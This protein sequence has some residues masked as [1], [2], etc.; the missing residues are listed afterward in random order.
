MNKKLYSRLDDHL[1]LAKK[2][3]RLITTHFLDENQLELAKIYLK[4]NFYQVSTTPINAKRKI[5]GFNGDPNDLIVCLV[6]KYQNN[7]I[8]LKYRDVYG[9]LMGLNL[10]PEVIGDINV[11]DDKVAI[12]IL[13]KV[14]DDILYNLIQINK[15]YLKFEISEEHYYKE[16]AFLDY[17]DIIS[18]LRLDCVVKSFAKVSRSHANDLIKQ[19]YVKINHLVVDKATTIVKENDI[20]SIRRSGRYIFDGV[21]KQ[22][23]KD[24]LLIQYRKYD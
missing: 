9:A 18:S 20:I 11:F 2:T 8:N 24:K 17:Q 6:A 14:K 16:N 5:I 13:D 10:S 23:K 21:I 22:T 4:N 15:I 19:Q 12:Y 1:F 7:F 3:N